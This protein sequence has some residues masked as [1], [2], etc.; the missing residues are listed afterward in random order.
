MSFESSISVANASGRKVIFHL[1][2]WGE[3]VQMPSGA[4]FVVVAEAEQVGSFEVEHGDVAITVW[5]W[6]SA[7]VKVLSGDKEIGISADIKRPAVPS[8]PKG[9]SVSSF[10]RSMFGK[11]GEV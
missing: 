1:E 3:E 5:A 9:Q 2:P 6:P 7:V 8:V 11:E 4:A 10:L